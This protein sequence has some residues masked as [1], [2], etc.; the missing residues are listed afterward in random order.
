MAERSQPNKKIK[1]RYGKIDTTRD[2]SPQG[3]G[4]QQA[5]PDSSGGAMTDPHDFHADEADVVLELVI[6]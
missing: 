6:D 2:V 3:G 5:S 4:L 1:P